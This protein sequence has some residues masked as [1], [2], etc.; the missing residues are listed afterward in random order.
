MPRLL[1]FRG[2]RSGD[3][4]H[5]VMFPRILTQMLLNCCFRLWTEQSLVVD[6]WGVRG[7]WERQE[8]KFTLRACLPGLRGDKIGK[9]SHHWA[10]KVFSLK[11]T[12]PTINLCL[13]NVDSI[14]L[15]AWEIHEK[16]EYPM[17]S[18]KG[19]KMENANLTIQQCSLLYIYSLL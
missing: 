1:V 7:R 19:W 13:T 2:E 5:S 17:T 11:T 15:N 8:W 10:L 12:L 6:R 18:W 4:S 9:H 3:T 14:I 16:H